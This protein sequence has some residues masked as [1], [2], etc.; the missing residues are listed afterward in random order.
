MTYPASRLA[1]KA[2]AAATSAVTADLL[3]TCRDVVLTVDPLNTPAVRAY[4]RLGYE[5]VSSIMESAAVRKEPLGVLSFARRRM[6]SW[7][8]RRHGGEVVYTP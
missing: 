1:R 5:H 8:G 7:R 3:R 6:A 2:T 4:R